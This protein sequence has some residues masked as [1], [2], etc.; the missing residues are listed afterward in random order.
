MEL[1]SPY[2]LQYLSSLSDLKKNFIYFV[3]Q[4]RKYHSQLILYT[5]SVI[6]WKIIVRK[7][8]ILTLP[9]ESCQSGKTQVNNSQYF[10]IEKFS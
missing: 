1:W 4:H 9:H 3:P 2:D 5:L 8:F 7:F 6:P 10:C